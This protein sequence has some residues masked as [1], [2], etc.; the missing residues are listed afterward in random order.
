[1]SAWLL[2]VQIEKESS[3]YPHQRELG[4]RLVGMKVRRRRGG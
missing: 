1:V 3:K 2:Y 4:F